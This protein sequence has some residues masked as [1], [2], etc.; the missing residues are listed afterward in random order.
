MDWSEDLKMS[1]LT[2]NFVMIYAVHKMLVLLQNYLNYLKDSIFECF[3]FSTYNA[4][5]FK[6]W[7]R[8]HN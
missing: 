6:S 2:F 8:K 4:G 7:R 1:F 3:V 5:K